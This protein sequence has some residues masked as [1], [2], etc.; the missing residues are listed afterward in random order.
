[1]RLNAL[2]G[3]WLSVGK[4]DSLLVVMKAV[5]ELLLFIPLSK[6]AKHSA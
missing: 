3:R 2:F 4:T 6:L 1:M 5:N